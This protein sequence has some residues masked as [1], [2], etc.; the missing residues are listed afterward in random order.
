MWRA[1]VVAPFHVQALART[2]DTIQ[3]TIVAPLSASVG[4]PGLLVNGARD[5]KAILKA[6][7][8]TM[9]SKGASGAVF[10]PETVTALRIGASMH[11]RVVSEVERRERLTGQDAEVQVGVT[12]PSHVLAK[13]EDL[14]FVA[15]ISTASG[16]EPAVFIDLGADTLFRSMTASDT[17]EV[18]QRLR[19]SAI[20]CGVRTTLRL[21][22]YYVR[23]RNQAGANPTYCHYGMS[24]TCVNA[25]GLMVVGH[26]HCNM[27][28][29]ID[30]DDPPWMR[31]STA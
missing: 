5:F 15:R 17:F 16:M 10:P 18:G 29:T 30:H 27:A 9:K 1:E 21:T 14:C 7:K 24:A 12:K 6:V 13:A 23:R 28:Y 19:R 11:P 2:V 26:R 3:A 20:N 22:A 31:W 8:D 4:R 25:G